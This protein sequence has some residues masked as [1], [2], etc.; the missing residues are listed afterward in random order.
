[1]P[2]QK[3]ISI[4]I[5]AYNEERHLGVCLDAVAAQLDAHDEVIV[6]DNNS[7]DRTAQIARRYPFVR[8]VRAR[9]QGVVFARDAGFNAARGAVIARIDADIVLPPGW[10]EHVRRFYASPAHAQ[11]A[12]TG[13]GF[14]YNMR[15]PRVVS[16]WYEFFVF[17]CNRVLLGHYTL[18]GSNMALPR[19]LWWAVRDSVHHRTGIH[20]DLDLALHLHH[21]GAA[22]RYDRSIKTNAR[23]KR[24]RS[25]RGQ[26][27]EYLQWWPRTLRLHRHY[28]GW[29]LAWLLSA[30]VFYGG[31]YIMVIVE[32]AARRLGRTPLPD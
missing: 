4:V 26:L 12:W 17:W 20:E 2:A 10:V 13:C 3:R 27:W 23:L 30:S 5:P 21:A 16:W 24:V 25:D 31:S 9:R 22:I 1:M 32:A 19:P 6:V 7:T 8:L 28:L 14:F 29:L 15:F 18:W 11:T